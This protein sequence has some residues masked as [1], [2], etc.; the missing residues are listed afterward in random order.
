VIFL[1]ARWPRTSAMRKKTTSG[2]K[3]RAATSMRKRTK[4]TKTA[5][6]VKNSDDANNYSISENMYT[7]LQTVFK[8][9][10]Y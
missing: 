4:S 10:C 6:K 3:R 8:N 5:R 7:V 2:K 1:S 9:M